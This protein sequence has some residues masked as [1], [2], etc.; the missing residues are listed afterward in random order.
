MNY[1]IAN[2]LSTLQVGD[3][4]GNV[5]IGTQHHGYDSSDQNNMDKSNIASQGKFK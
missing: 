3:I 5:E 2:A 4:T 1:V